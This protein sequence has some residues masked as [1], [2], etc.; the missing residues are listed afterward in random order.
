VFRLLTGLRPLELSEINTLWAHIE[1]YAS[2]LAARL[3]TLPPLFKGRT[4]HSVVNSVRSIFSIAQ[5][6]SASMLSSFQSDSN[7]NKSLP[8]SYKS[9]ERKWYQMSHE[10][11]GVDK[12]TTPR[13]ASNGNNRANSDINM[14]QG[15]LELLPYQQRH[16]SETRHASDTNNS[17]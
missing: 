10:V 13:M 17:A 6:K 7:R 8:L 15:S 16:P 4:L 9:D 3:P 2:T 11:S 5:S 12:I 1:A 14:S